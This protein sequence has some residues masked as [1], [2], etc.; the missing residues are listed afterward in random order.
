MLWRHFGKD[1][2]DPFWV[3]LS[4]VFPYLRFD[5]VLRFWRFSQTNTIPVR[6]FLFNPIQAAPPPIKPL[7]I[8]FER[9]VF[10][11]WNFLTFPKILIGIK[12]QKNVFSRK[13]C[14][15]MVTIFLWL[16]GTE[17]LKFLKSCFFWFFYQHMFNNSHSPFR[18]CKQNYKIFFCSK[19]ITFQRKYVFWR[20]FD[21]FWDVFG[22]VSKNNDVINFLMT[23]LY[24]LYGKGYVYQLSC[25]NDHFSRNYV[26]GP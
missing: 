11:P 21:I 25:K 20:K 3:Y 24:S 4:K 10:L 2:L 1:L 6:F 12:W 23:D 13:R 15:A 17:K 14:V 9:E 18:I 5:K 26:G 8:T 19:V 16:V 7:L 22:D